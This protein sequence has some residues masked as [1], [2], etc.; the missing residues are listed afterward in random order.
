MTRRRIVGTIGLLL[1]AGGGF[2]W[3]RAAHKTEI[4]DDTREVRVT[5][6][7]IELSVLTTGDVRPR[8]RL[9]IKPPIPGRAEEILVREGDTVRKGQILAWMSSTDRAALL[10]AARAKGDAELARWEE[11]YKPTPL[12]APLNGSIIARNVEPGQT[13]SG[14]DAVLIISDRLV[15]K[16]QVDET[17]MAQV[18]LGQ[19]VGIVLDAFAQENISGVVEHIA[20]EAKTVNNV[21]IYEVDVLPS[22]VPLFM[23]S[24]MTANLTFHVEEKQ[25]VLLLPPAA[26]KTEGGASVVT[27]PGPKGKSLTVAVQTG[28]SNGKQVEI[29]S[30]VAE[31]DAVLISDGLPA[32][33][34]KAKTSPLSPVMRRPRRGAR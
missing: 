21:T 14:S 20:F 18:R 12:V 19:S 16:A 29:V 27:V 26:V 25:N 2:L 7:N 6:G 3:W 23:R 13:V 10:D 11:L 30:G 31:G 9:E 17:D 4:S 8:N 28:L 34:A 32:P 24:G 5:R 33:A 1:L 22:R 15:L